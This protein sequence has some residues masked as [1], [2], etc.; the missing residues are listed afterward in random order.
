MR[1]LET[2]IPAGLLL[3]LKFPIAFHTTFVIELCEFPALFRH[4]LCA[5][6][7]GLLHTSLPN[8][9]THSRKW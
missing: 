8:Y 9:F 2:L 6:I 7:S 3:Q 4:S 1:S 5:H